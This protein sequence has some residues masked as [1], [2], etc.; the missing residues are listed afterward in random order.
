MMSTNFLPVDLHRWDHGPGGDALV[1]PVWS[2]VRPL[3]GAAGLLDWRLCGRLSKMLQAGRFSGISGE[4]LLLA[5]SRIPWQRVLAVG[6]GESI[7]FD[8]HAFRSAIECCLGALRGLGTSSLAIAFPGRDIDLVRPD[9]AMHVFLDAL[10]Q[11]E[12][13]G[14]PWLERLTVID[15]AASAK[16]SASAKSSVSA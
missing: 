4:K 9:R 12:L 2:D 13:T 7:A 8:D 16:V 5:T 1:V 14:G 3:R 6:V 15:A 11:S 10:A